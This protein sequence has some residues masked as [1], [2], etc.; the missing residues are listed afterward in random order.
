MKV[1]LLFNPPFYLQTQSA[2]WLPSLLT[3]LLLEN[4]FVIAMT[5]AIPWPHFLSL[6]L[7]F[8]LNLYFTV[9]QI[10]IPMKK[11]STLFQGSSSQIPPFW[12][13][14]GR[15]IFFFSVSMLSSNQSLKHVSKCSAKPPAPRAWTQKTALS[16]P[17]AVMSTQFSKFTIQF[18]V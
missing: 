2:V 8:F 9:N 3:Q 1:K 18:T 6:H 5:L 17:R 7:T 11:L 10:T 13:Q 14:Q 4:N 15:V 16:M 12:I